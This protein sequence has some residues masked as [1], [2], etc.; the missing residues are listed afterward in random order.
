MSTSFSFRAIFFLI[1]FAILFTPIFNLAA[2]DI[3]KDFPVNLNAT[4]TEG[5]F[6]TANE[7]P[8]NEQ[9]LE[10]IIGGAIGFLLSF[11]SLI[12]FF[13]FFYGAYKWLLAKGD[14]E[15]INKAQKIIKASLW[16]ILI[17][18]LSYLILK[19]ILELLLLGDGSLGLYKNE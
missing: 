13:W 18:A 10:Q 5:G 14:D 15:K 7:T 2:A 17:I 1:F 9:K 16:G 19:L 6:I 12:F 3:E 4:A 8:P 11:T